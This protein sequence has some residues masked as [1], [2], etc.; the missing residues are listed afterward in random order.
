M[1]VYRPFEFKS[2]CFDVNYC[3]GGYEE[4]IR[5]TADAA[6]RRLSLPENSIGIPARVLPSDG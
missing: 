2:G 3:L 6:I 4:R 1:H 5:E